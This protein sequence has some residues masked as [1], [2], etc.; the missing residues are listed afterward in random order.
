MTG[1]GSVVM[2]THRSATATRNRVEP[3]HIT[4]Y[5]PRRTA[6]QRSRQI[7]ACIHRHLPTPRVRTPFG[8]VVV[9][10]TSYRTTYCA[11]HVLSPSIGQDELT[12]HLDFQFF[13]RVDLCKSFVSFGSVDRIASIGKLVKLKEN[14]RQSLWMRLISCLNTIYDKDRLEILK[15]VLNKKH[16]CF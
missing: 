3:S 9:T 12:R 6:P 8:I 7:H 5:R 13:L 15:I 16:D 14:T 11:P 1:G 10:R 2:A 4:H